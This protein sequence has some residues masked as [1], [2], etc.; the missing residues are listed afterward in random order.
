MLMGRACL[1][2]DPFSRPQRLEKA[3]ILFRTAV[4]TY[5]MA[6]GY[7]YLSLSF[8]RA[9]LL[10]DLQQAIFYAGQAIEN[11]SSEVRYWHLLGI[12]LS[13]AEQWKAAA[14]ILERGAALDDVEGP[15][16]EDDGVVVD[17]FQV[18]QKPPVRMKDYG[19]LSSDADSSAASTVRPEDWSPTP[20]RMHK[21]EVYLLDG[22]AQRV[23]S[24]SNL[25]G[26]IVD[27]CWPLCME[28]FEY[29]LQL[30]LTQVAITEAMEGPEGAEQ[31][32]VE[33]FAWIAAKKA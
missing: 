9:G 27:R 33:V 13:A 8:A 10:Q 15:A 25:L 20:T 28:I 26:S 7:F 14:E 30:R 32:W 24:S 12:L 31:K 11:D 5:P 21:E 6:L 19:L 22:N 3:H 18:D 17:N 23:P 29:S 1:E 16:P 4:E 2:Q